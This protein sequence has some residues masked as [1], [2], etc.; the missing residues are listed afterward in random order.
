M[1]YR[2]GWSFEVDCEVLF[3]INSNLYCRWSGDFLEAGK[4]SLSGDTVREANSDEVV[5][6]V[7]LDRPELDRL[8]GKGHC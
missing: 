5:V 8:R 7:A 1:Q 2:N 6:Y 4:N 3:G